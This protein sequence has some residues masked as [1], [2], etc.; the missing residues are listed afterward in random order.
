[1]DALIADPTSPEPPFIQKVRFTLQHLISTNEITDIMANTQT[2][3]SSFYA[4]VL[5]LAPGD[6]CSRVRAVDPTTSVERLPDELPEIKQS[7]R[8][9]V[10]PAVTNAREK[11]GGTYTIEVGEIVMPKGKMYV[12]AVVTR[13]PE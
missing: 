4:Q 6:S 9:A 5:D 1:M 11:T 8:N 2:K 7:L 3:S 13:Q 10:T 12:V